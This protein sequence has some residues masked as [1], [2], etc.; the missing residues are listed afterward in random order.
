MKRKFK[1]GKELSPR[2]LEGDVRS[3]VIG[4]DFANDRGGYAKWVRRLGFEEEVQRRNSGLPKARMM[5]NTFP[6]ITSHI[7]SPACGFR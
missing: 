1:Y 5:C 3:G 2:G 6:T 4:L 7:G